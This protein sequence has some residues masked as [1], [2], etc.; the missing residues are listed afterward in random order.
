MLAVRSVTLL[1]RKPHFVLGLSPRSFAGAKTKR[2][3]Q[4]DWNSETVPFCNIFDKDWTRSGHDREEDRGTKKGLF[5]LPEIVMG[6]TK[7]NTDMWGDVWGELERMTEYEDEAKEGAVVKAVKCGVGIACK[8]SKLDF[9]FVV[10]A[11]RLDEPPEEIDN[12][13]SFYFN[14]GVEGIS[15]FFQSRDGDFTLFNNNLG[16]HNLCLSEYV[17]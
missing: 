10:S 9:L 8:S 14:H 12:Q 5:P 15:V 1:S 16:S 13:K 17:H 2:T 11:Q 6:D 4:G 3:R 7:N